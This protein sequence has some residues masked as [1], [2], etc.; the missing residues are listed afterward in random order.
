M[1]EEK[2]ISRARF[3][4]ELEEELKSSREPELNKDGLRLSSQAAAFLLGDPEKDPRADLLDREQARLQE[5][6]EVLLGRVDEFGTRTGE[7]SVAKEAVETALRSY[8]ICRENEL[9]AAQLQSMLESLRAVVGEL[10]PVS[11]EDRARWGREEPLRL[12]AQLGSI[13]ARLAA[14]QSAVDHSGGRLSALGDSLALEAELERAMARKQDLEQKNAALVLALDCLAEANRDLQSRFSP[15]VC[16]RAAELFSRLT[17]GRYARVLL[18]SDLSVAVQE[19][20]APE[21]RMLQLLSAGT[22]DQLYLA[23]RLAIS[24][25][26]LPDAPLVLDDALVA[27]DDERAK[28]ALEVLQEEAEKRQILLFTCQSREAQLLRS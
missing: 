16:E 24:E 22:V 3:L 17:G 27:F 5:A 18:S 23:L 11:E 12:A 14:L 21:T 26:L 4:E 2:R 19:P 25:L 7:L 10:K 9:R 20:E 8:T 6:S 13:E 28:A 15:L 1:S